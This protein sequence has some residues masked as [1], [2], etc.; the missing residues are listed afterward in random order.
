MRL[1][2]DI[3]YRH[4]SA[5]YSVEQY[6]AG[7]DALMLKSVL[8]YETNQDLVDGYIYLLD[9]NAFPDR[10]QNNGFLLICIDGP[11]PEPWR[12]EHYSVIAMLKPVKLRSVLNCIQAIFD[13]YRDWD[14]QL[15]SILNDDACVEKL[16]LCS[17]SILDNPLTVTNEQLRILGAIG[18]S[19]QQQDS[20][21]LYDYPSIPSEHVDRLR[22]IFEQHHKHRE[23]FLHDDNGREIVYS[24]NIYFQEKYRG[25][26][27]MSEL[28][29]PFHRCDLALFRHFAEYVHRAMVSQLN[30]RHTRFGP[31]RK[32][33]QDLLDGSFIEEAQLVSALSQTMISHN[34]PQLSWIC[35][36]LQPHDHS[37]LSVPEYIIAAI[38][39]RLPKCIATP[40]NDNIVLLDKLPPGSEA[41]YTMVEKIALILQSAGFHIGVS[42]RFREMHDLRIAYEKARC[43]IETGIALGDNSNVYFFTDHTFLYMLQQAKGTFQIQD[44]LPSGLVALQRHDEE[45][46][47]SYIE[48][49]RSYLSCQMSV[50]KTARAMFLHRS[51][52]TQRLDKI[53]DILGTRLESADEQLFYLLLL[54][55][56]E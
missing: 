37:S 36:V 52:L 31:I 35:L 46:A 2:P 23:P 53:F 29:R 25:C 49:L 13:R 48:T 17:V 14:E 6:G 24:I 30:V 33:L 21:F 50:A 7:C 34:D 42:D 1:S 32:A 12:D 26:V 39:E 10:P 16:L 28:H 18:Y 9:Q 54:R 51:S 43:A 15:Q 19:G 3:V 27:S 40:Y 47:I 8:L 5:S 44:L 38:V 20:W 22:E 55:I 56:L 11:P 4:L 45:S 41:A